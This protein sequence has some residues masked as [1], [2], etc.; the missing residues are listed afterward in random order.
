MNLSSEDIKEIASALSK[1]QSQMKVPVKDKKN[2]HF[3]NNYASL[4]SIITA[5]KEALN[6]NGLSISQQITEKEGIMILVTSL[7]HTSGQFLRSYAPIRLANGKT[8]PQELGSYLTYLKRYSLSSLL[9]LD[10]DEDD[11]GNS[12]SQQNVNTKVNQPEITITAEQCEVINDLLSINEDIKF[13]AI[14]AFRQKFG[15]EKLC[16]IPASSFP[17]ILSWIKGLVDKVQK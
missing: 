13:E 5:C 12:A 3:R 17:A 1:A 14:A 15:S 8:G 9:C 4:G 10:A 7:M 2:P 6:N 16:D 11:D